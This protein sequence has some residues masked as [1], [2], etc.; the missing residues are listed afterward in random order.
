MKSFM[1]KYGSLDIFNNDITNS[2]YLSQGIIPDQELIEKHLV[3]YLLQSSTLINVGS[4]I[5]GHDLL[6]TKM[7]ILN[8]N[9]S[10][11]Q[12]NNSI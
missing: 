2:K 11:S 8:Q 10:S 9:R 12:N 1:T 3:E 7:N 6:F 4:G 5:G